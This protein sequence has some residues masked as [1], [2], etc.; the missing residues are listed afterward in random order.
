MRFDI[1]NVFFSIGDR[2]I[3]QVLG[4]PMGSPCSPPLAIALCMFAEH[5]FLQSVNPDD[6]LGF[7]YMDDLILFCPS[8]LTFEEIAAIY[9]PPLQLKEEKPSSEGWEFLE[10]CLSWTVGGAP[11]VAYLSKNAGR[12]RL[13]KPLL[14]NC[15]HFST[16]LPFSWQFGRV[17]GKLCRIQQNALGDFNHLLGAGF[18]YSEFLA[19]GACPGLLLKA[20]LRMTRKTNGDSVWKQALS[21]A[22]FPTSSC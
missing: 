9:P 1:E 16:S 4:V 7:R 10:S 5:K 2:L 13:G 18:A 12:A 3:H 22:L 21:Q 15:P 14:R 11:C 6:F 17:V 19:L 20:A 8:S